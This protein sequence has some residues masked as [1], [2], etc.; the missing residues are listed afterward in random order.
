MTEHVPKEF[1]AFIDVAADAILRRGLP[2][3]FKA[4]LAVRLLACGQV[5]NGSLIAPAGV[6][7]CVAELPLQLA[8]IVSIDRRAL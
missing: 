3:E 2:P 1:S 7:Q 6:R 8:L 5:G 4:F